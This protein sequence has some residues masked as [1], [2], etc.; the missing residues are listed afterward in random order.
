MIISRSVLLRE[1]NAVDKICRG[2]QI[3]KIMFRTFFQKSCR[4]LDNVEKY[5]RA[6]PATN[7]SIIGRMP[8]ACWITNAIYTH[9]E[10]VI[11]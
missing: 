10:Y 5:G 4:L 1:V 6:R 8:F 2:N 7:V 3:T 9:S 11:P